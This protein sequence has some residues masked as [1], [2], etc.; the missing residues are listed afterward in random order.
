LKFT[1]VS[2]TRLAPLWHGYALLRDAPD[3]LAQGDLP[4]LFWCKRPLG[5]AW[6]VDLWALPE[7]DAV[8]D[9]A[10][11]LAT[12][13]GDT[14]DECVPLTLV[15]PARGRWRGAYLNEGKLVAALI[16]GR[17]PEM[18]HLLPF[19]TEPSLA[20]AQEVLAGRVAAPSAGPMV[21]A[22]FQVSAARIRAVVAS[23][24][25]TSVD[26]IGALLKAGTNCG[27]CIS[28]LKGFLRHADA[29][30]VA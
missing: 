18:D 23:G 4:G 21:C 15:D 11:L 6:A 30:L 26:A 7:S 14:A 12:L 19:F 8:P 9:G 29:S 25:A 5:D 24:E 16:L 10:A 20:N 1:P 13:L 3:P 22:C 27:S 2:L 17:G 28:E